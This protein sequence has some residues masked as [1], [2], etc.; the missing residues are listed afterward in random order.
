MTQVEREHRFVL[1]RPQA[2]AFM[3]AAS[4]HLHLDV[5]D[6]SNPVCYARTTYFDS[7]EG[8]YLRSCA[9]P[10]ARR[11]RLREYAGAS[12]LDAPVT[13]TGV[14]FLEY[15]ESAGAERTKVRWRAPADVMASVVV[16]RALARRWQAQLDA[17]A[18]LADIA[19]RIRRGQLAPRLVTWYRRVSL[20][21]R[22]VRVTMDEGVA[23]CRPSAAAG[24]RAAQPAPRA[25]VGTVNGRIVEVKITGEPPAWLAAA[26][27]PLPAAEGFSK[28][29]AGMAAMRRARSPV[30]HSRTEPLPVVAP[31]RSR[32]TGT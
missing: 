14:C 19:A 27:A 31:I 24:D 15:K 21:A 10:I 2:E 9:G 11:A 23:L 8:D 26:M 4:R 12:S 16:G 32:G 3:A 1:A 17:H 29:R 22:G 18:V 25:V 30:P 5:Y 20:S 7:D 28:F 13:L 6:P